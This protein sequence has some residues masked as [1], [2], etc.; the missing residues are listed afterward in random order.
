MADNRESTVVVVFNALVTFT[1]EMTGYEF[2]HL[3]SDIVRCTAER[4]RFCVAVDVFLTH[5][6]ICDL[7]VTLVV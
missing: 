4:G 1:N 5:A 3:G 7:D 2:P 6:E